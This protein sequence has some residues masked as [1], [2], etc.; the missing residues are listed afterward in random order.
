MN[1]KMTCL[2]RAGWCSPPD[3]VTAFGRCS[4]AA[5]S[6]CDTS[7]ANAIMPKP[8]PMR[9]S[10]SRRVTGG[11]DRCDMSAHKQ[12]LVRAQQHFDVTAER[13]D[14]QHLLLLVLGGLH[15]G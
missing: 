15:A 5:E 2:A 13:R 14:R 7:P 3:W 10:A 11:R 8:L 12:E 6:D 4:A 9:Q 1:R